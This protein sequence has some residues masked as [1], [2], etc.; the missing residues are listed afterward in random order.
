M[1]KKFRIAIVEDCTILREGLRSLLGMSDFEIVG[2]EED[3]FGAISCVENYQPDLV[4]LDLSMPKMNG[5]SAIKD[6]KRVSP[7][8][9]I[10]TL[11]VHEEDEY[12]L[13]AFRSGADGY[14][15][16]DTNHDE[17]ISG[18]KTVLSGK[19][20]FSPGVSEK[21]LEGY[22]EGKK[23]LKPKSSWETITAR[24]REILKLVGEGYK[25]KKI[26]ELLCLSEKTVEKHRA[27]IMEK[28]KVHNTAALTAFA[29]EK[30]LV[31]K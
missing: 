15:L 22:L 11:T 18:I 7:K 14:C 26:A 12:I 6:I 8:T 13:E 27:N 4:L 24:E 5:L 2:E 29:I 30:G 31:N 3:G 1:G 16:K 19:P 9:K 10:L 17:L 28:L 20:Y 21:V 25:N 23:K